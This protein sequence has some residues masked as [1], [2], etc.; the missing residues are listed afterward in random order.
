MPDIREQAETLWHDVGVKYEREN[1][2]DLKDKM[3]FIKPDPEHYPLGIERPN[4]GCR[5]LMYHHFSKILTGINND[6]SDWQAA[7]RI[8][9]AQLLYTL[10]INLEENVTMHLEKVIHALVK[11]S[12]DEEPRV[13]EHV[14]KS[15]TLIGYF[16]PPEIWVKMILKQV[17]LYQNP[18][19]LRILSGVISGSERGPL[20]SFLPD[21]CSVVG[22]GQISQVADLQLQTQ[23]CACL[24]EIIKIAGPTCESVSLDMFAIILGVCAL[25]RSDDIHAKGTALLSDLAQAQGMA[26]KQEL[27]ARHSQE[28]V[29]RLQ[30]NSASWTQHSTERLVF[31]TLLMES[32]PVVGEMIETILPMLQA[33]LQPEKDVEVRLKFFKLLSQLLVKASS[34]LNSQGKF[35]QQ[36]VITVIRNIILP[37]C[38]WRA[39]RTAG[40]LRT[41]AISSLWALL[42]GDEAPLV[43]PETLVELADPLVTQLK[44][45]LEDDINSTRLLTCRVLTRVFNRAGPKMDLDQLHQFYPEILKRLDDASDDIRCAACLTFIAYLQSFR[46]DYAVS[47]WRAHYEAIYRGLLVHLDDPERRIQ[48]EVLKVLESAAE[49]D[50][51]LLLKEI[52]LVKHKHRST[53]YCDLL[54]KHIH[55]LPK[56]DQSGDS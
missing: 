10:L 15:S 47:L 33:N 34:T 12:S 13:V 9:A 40:A 54:V 1:E 18:G 37:N 25:A 46:A 56:P 42:H 44:S 11:G 41:V 32:G 16:V 28:M 5:T 22:D 8:K 2:N 23:L 24:S 35:S 21:I 50:P 17:K 53:H 3:D 45:M 55:S 31:E 39:G 27:F 51:S 48:E 52:D 29:D 20:T 36:H 14:E 38:V 4:L 30:S 49:I 6:I 43:T 19:L 7:S 26:D